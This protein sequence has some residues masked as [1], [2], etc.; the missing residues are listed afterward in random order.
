MCMLVQ[1]TPYLLS[2]LLIYLLPTLTPYASTRQLGRTL[3][4]ANVQ[5]EFPA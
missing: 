5:Y 1:I 4:N 3:E 2:C